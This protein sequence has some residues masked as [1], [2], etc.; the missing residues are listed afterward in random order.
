MKQVTIQTASKTYEVKIGVG[1]TDNI[2]SF[3]KESYP[4]VSQ[5]M[6]HC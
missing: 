2:V 1:M 3:I 6:D 5:G 4:R